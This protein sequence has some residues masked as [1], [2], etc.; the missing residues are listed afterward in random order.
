MIHFSECREFQV[1]W[2]VRGDQVQF[3]CNLRK[4]ELCDSFLFFCNIVVIIAR[5]RRRFVRL[6]EFEDFG[7][8]LR[9]RSA[10]LELTVI[11]TILKFDTFSMK[12]RLVSE[13]RLSRVIIEKR[14]F[15]TEFYINVVKVRWILKSIV[16]ITII[17][18]SKASIHSRHENCRVCRQT[19]LS[20]RSCN[21]GRNF[22]IRLFGNI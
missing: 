1:Y 6:D 2:I 4:P 18:R 19:T 21:V 11:I 10:I 14:S 13:K 9:Q 17:C 15:F 8:M 5:E 3:G 7:K 16:K 12:L 20:E 22:A